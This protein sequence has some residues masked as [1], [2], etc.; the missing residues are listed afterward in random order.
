MNA[1][2]PRHLWLEVT[3]VDTRTVSRRVRIR[4]G[5]AVCRPSFRTLETF[6]RRG[7]SPKERSMAGTN[8]IGGEAGIRTLDTAFRPYNGLANRPLQ[9]LGHLTARP[10]VYVTKM[11]T[12]KRS[13]CEGDPGSTDA[14]ALNATARGLCIVGTL[15]VLDTTVG[16]TAG[17]S[18]RVFRS[19]N[20]RHRRETRK[21]TV[22][23][24]VAHHCRT[25]DD[26][27]EVDRTRRD[28]EWPCVVSVVSVALASGRRREV[29]GARLESN[30]GDA[31]RATPKQ[32]V[33]Q[34][35]QRLGAIECSS[36]TR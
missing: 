36:V 7:G 20:S 17:T 30:S 1:T 16:H 9:P 13:T 4:P 2:R 31:Q 11:F 19:I 29:E 5:S 14:S 21:A 10:Q 12:Q 27:P 24:A 33:A 22:A 25:L 6:W 26:R 15:L 8:L 34:S 35:I 3:E 28:S 18:T 32:L 23:N